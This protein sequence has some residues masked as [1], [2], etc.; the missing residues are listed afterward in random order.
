MNI[1]KRDELNARGRIRVEAGK[2]AATRRKGER[3]GLCAI[4]D[5]V[6]TGKHVV[7]VEIVVD[8]GD[9]AAQVVK[10]RRSYRSVWIPAD[11]AAVFPI[12]KR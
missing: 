11:A 6:A 10:R 7:F 3:E 1:G 4:A 2:L 8:L 9:S 12:H 5:E